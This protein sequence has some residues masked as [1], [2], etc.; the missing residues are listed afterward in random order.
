M[1]TG[2]ALVAI[3]LA[4]GSVSGAHANPIV[5]CAD[6][7]LGGL[8]RVQLLVYVA[9]SDRRGAEVSEIAAEK[10]GRRSPPYDARAGRGSGSNRFVPPQIASRQLVFER[11]EHRSG[12]TGT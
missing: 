6:A 7:F 9:G 2:A 10:L 3:I 8:S 11:S 1:A 12:E 4:V 5:S